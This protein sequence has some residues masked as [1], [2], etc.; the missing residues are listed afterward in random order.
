MF[1]FS[2]LFSPNNWFLWI[3]LTIV[4][5]SFYF[6]VRR[7]FLGQ[8]D[9]YSIEGDAEQYVGAAES[10]SQHG[11]FRMERV[12]RLSNFVK[13]ADLKA[14]EYCFRMP[15]FAVIYVPLRTFLSK[16]NTCK[17]IIG[18]Q[19]VLSALSKYLLCLL[20]IQLIG[21]GNAFYLCLI[22][23]N[24]SPYSVLFNSLLLT[25]S[26]AQ[27]L[28]IIAV[29]LC[30]K[31]PV[32]NYFRVLLIGFCLFEAFW[33][34]PFMGVL[35]PLFLLYF[36]VNDE[37]LNFKKYLFLLL[38]LLLIQ[39]FWIYRNYTVTGKIIPISS[40]MIWKQIANGVYASLF[41]VT[42]LAGGDTEFWADE[43]PMHWLISA[44]QDT[45]IPEIFY[46][47]LS[48]PKAEIDKLKY[49]K[50]YYVASEN[51]S[52]SLSQRM[53]AELDGRN[54]VDN[55]IRIE[56]ADNYF[57]KKVKSS[58]YYARML[59]N[60]PI[61][62]YFASIKYPFNVALTALEY[63]LIRLVFYFGMCCSVWYI[64]KFMGNTKA[65]NAGIFAVSFVPVFLLTFFSLM[66]SNEFREL[67]LAF[68]FLIIA[69]LHFLARPM[70]WNVNYILLL[71]FM[72]VILFKTKVYLLDSFRF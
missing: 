59:L 39:P 12:P 25:E 15:G 55:L 28:I 53:K 43:S 36:W 23:V 58:F 18:L 38:P 29:Y 69:I 44:P 66:A 7:D 8:N 72:L 1:Q 50:E 11:E 3:G 37:K 42:Q 62:R 5:N 35:F 6:D 54:C 30:I 61:L 70:K 27:S 47:R 9:L 48:A 20:L 41:K 26:L 17:A 32:N 45:L 51:K 2:K 63:F 34:R 10:L 46:N 33:L 49:A 31:Q 64:I 16:D 4:I 40:T 22:L 24:L 60:Q 67:Y 14:L 13:E 65:G 21:R 56:T 68:P 19:I 57:K 52:L 71:F